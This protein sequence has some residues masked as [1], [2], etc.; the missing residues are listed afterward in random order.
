MRAPVWR[1]ICRKCARRSFRCRSS[2]SPC[3]RRHLADAIPVSIVQMPSGIPVATVAINGGAN[4]GLL[5]E[6]LATSDDAILQKL[7]QYSEE[8]KDRSWQR[9]PDCRKLDIRITK[10]GRRRRGFLWRHFSL[11]RKLCCK[12][13]SLGKDLRQ[14]GIV[15]HLEYDKEIVEFY[16]Y[17]RH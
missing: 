2:E 8:L 15:L 11:F 5:A 7:K 1:R 4:A 9:T 6:I 17:W 13:S 3:I 12:A 16:V 10:N 14:Y